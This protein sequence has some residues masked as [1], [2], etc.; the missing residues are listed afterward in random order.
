MCMR[1]R[2]RYQGV[3]EEGDG[4]ASKTIVRFA[5]CVRAP[6]VYESRDVEVR[7]D[8]AVQRGVQPP[9]EW[10]S[11][12]GWRAGTPAVDEFAEKACK[13]ARKDLGL[14]DDVKLDC[15]PRLP[16]TRAR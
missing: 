3:V 13:R 7:C 9:K 14:G 1:P 6:G 16:K 4:N 10:T 11:R 8:N 15:R 2:C 12:L 5:W